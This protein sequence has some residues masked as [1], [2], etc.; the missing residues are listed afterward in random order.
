MKEAI[1]LGVACLARTTFDYDAAEELWRKIQG[2]LE[3]LEN[4]T[5]ITYDKL[6]FEVEDAKQAASIFARSKVD[7]LVIISGTF[8]LGHLALELVKE[9]HAPILLWGL[10]ELPYNG[11]KIRLNSVCGVNLNAS[12]LFKAG[13]KNYHVTIGKKIDENWVDAVRVL[14]ALSHAHVGILGARAH[15]FFNLGV[16]DLSL[17]Q[18]TGVL[19]DY[20][21]LSEVWHFPVNEEAIASRASKLKNIF[22]VSG[23]SAA[24]LQK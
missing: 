3:R 9:V 23:I 2:D 16:A 14:A 8:H 6:I 11:G 18:H 12:N 15:G 22:D 24:Q 10:P 1:T 5:I 17:Y 19:I 13:I 7:G 21:D 4:V 20:Y